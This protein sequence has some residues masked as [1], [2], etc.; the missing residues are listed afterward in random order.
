MAKMTYFPEGVLH[1]S[2]RGPFPLEKNFHGQKIFRKIRQKICA[3]H[4]LQNFLSAENF[5]EAK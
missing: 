5:P 3:N 1:P 4:I 2:V